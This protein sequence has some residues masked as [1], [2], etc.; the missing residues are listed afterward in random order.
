MLSGSGSDTVASGQSFMVSL[1]VELDPKS[2]TAVITN[3]QFLNS[4]TAAANDPNGGL[5]SDISDDPLN[6][7][8]ID[9]E[10]DNDAD[11]PTAVPVTDATIGAAKSAIWDDAN[12]TATVNLHL[13][14]LG[15]IDA[16][17]LSLREDLDA[18]FGTGNYAVGGLMM[19]SGPSTVSAN[20][21][22]NGS[23]NQ[24]LLA[25]GSSMLPG[26]TAHVQ[27][28]V[29][30]TEIAD[31]QGNGLGFFENQVTVSAE[32][33]LGDLFVDDSTDGTDPDPNNDGVP[34]DNNVPSN[35]SLTPDATLGLAKH[36]TLSPDQNFVTFLFTLENFGNTIA[37]GISAIDSLPSVFGAGNYVVTSVTRPSG[38]ASF[39]A[40]GM[41]DG[42]G[43]PELVAAGSTLA[44]DETATIEVVVDITNTLDGEYGN[45][46]AVSNTDGDGNP[47]TDDSQ[48]GLDPDANLN[49]DPTDDSG[50]TLMSIHRGMV[51]GTVYA[52]FNNDG[53]QDVGEPGIP[54]VEIILTGVVMGVPVTF[55]TLTDSNGDYLFNLL[56][57]GDYTLMQTHPEAFLDGIDSAGSLGGTVTN[58]Q[59]SFTLTAA[60]NV[61]SGYNFGEIGIDPFYSGKDP[62]LSSGQGSSGGGTGP[63]G[64][65]ETDTAPP[66]IV[67]GNRLTVFGTTNDDVYRVQLGDLEHE[68]TIDFV[69]YAFDAEEINQIWIGG[70]GGDDAVQII[71]SAADETISLQP[72]RGALLG[73]G[74][75][76]RVNNV[77]QIAVD[78]GAGLDRATL[79]GSSGDDV[80]NLYPNQGDLS[81]TDFLHEVT[82]VRSMDVYPG[83]GGYDRVFHHDSTGDD[84]ATAKPAWSRL[85]GYGFQ[86]VAYAFDRVNLYAVAG[87]QDEAQLHDTTGDDRYFGYSEY[88]VLRTVGTEYYGKATGFDRVIAMASVGNDRA[89]LFDTSGN[90]RFIARPNNAVLRGT[91]DEYYNKVNGF[92][93]VVA[94]GSTGGH[95]QAVFYD[96]SSADTF[97]V[98]P[99]LAAL[100]GNDGR[101]ENQ[102]IGFETVYGHSVGGSDTAFVHDTLGD[103]QFTS[104]ESWATIQSNAHQYFGY[105]GGFDRVYAYGS[106]GYDQAD[107]HDGAGDD[108]F[109]GRAWNAVMRGEAD[110]FYNK[111]NNF[112]R[113]RAF[114]SE[115]NDQA[116]LFDSAG[117]DQL[118][119]KPRNSVLRSDDGRFYTKVNHFDRVVAESQSGDDVARFYD[120]NGREHFVAAP[121]YANMRAVDNSFNNLATG[122]SE[123]LAVAGG[124]GDIALLRD[125]DGDDVFTSRRSY[126]SLRDT[127]GQYNNTVQGFAEVRAEASQGDDLAVISEV[128]AVEMLY[129]RGSMAHLY[130][131]HRDS[132]AT[133][134]EQVMGYSLDDEWA[135]SDIQDVDYYFAQFGNWS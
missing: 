28:V 115:G 59:I 104:T 73:N 105:A 4:A 128:G 109:I 91:H 54:D 71:G 25:A 16:L 56:E 96:S 70:G 127:Q 64:D 99:G 22:F 95:D 89:Q 123:I 83:D 36:A 117:N 66:F 7:S 116:R 130:G 38:P 129:G 68:V 10:G 88:T 52:D 35:G 121:H 72:H 120:S 13:E 21:S 125:S 31:P 30:I 32:N 112:D 86:N 98:R 113:V 45:A 79:I 75:E 11:D 14:H 84:E 119:A 131:Q 80:A 97:V 19:V 9:S 29:T 101:F 93:Q 17:N 94:H 81:G 42:D 132:M 110:V 69:A 62:F 43:D 92:D 61:A 24:E 6:T 126:S 111:V 108:V 26:E 78:G 76:V 15:T 33:F 133:G 77:D 51:S 3:G 47:F 39:T 2:P 57:A 106:E 65:A 53:V 122:F 90:D 5:V 67:E 41:F 114:A 124:G 48:P 23:G 46:A 103:D 50:L 12:D 20:G 85:R 118:I 8:D 27:F 1:V 82:A 44:P 40:N 100:R 107:L 34:T 18:V 37:T 63:S 102:A 55:V 74:Y 58:D 87:G 135:Q 60:N 49:D 134:F